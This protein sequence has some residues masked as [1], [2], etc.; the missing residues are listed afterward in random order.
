[1]ESSKVTRA[2]EDVKKFDLTSSERA[3]LIEALLLVHEAETGRPF[4]RGTEPLPSAGFSPLS[5]NTI[6][7]AQVDAIRLSDRLL[8]LIGVIADETLAAKF[9]DLYYPEVERLF[10]EVVN[11]MP[12][13]TTISTP[14]KMV[15]DRLVAFSGFRK[16]G[17][18]YDSGTRARRLVA[19]QF[20]FLMMLQD[21]FKKSIQS[22]MQSLLTVET[23]R[24]A[25]L[26][27]GEAELRRRLNGK[28]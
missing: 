3:A 22:L 24:Y 9:V 7:N 8:F 19:D 26:A 2:L 16:N 13:E 20:P 21:D 25:K 5:A 12:H 14:L 1:M 17:A 27:E 4:T 6:V 28:S 15:A 11:L 23:E 10:N 18:N